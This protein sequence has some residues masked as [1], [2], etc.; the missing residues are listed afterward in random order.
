MRNDLFLMKCKHAN[1]ARDSKG[2]PVCV[3]CGC[4]DVVKK[5]KQPTDGLEGRTAKCPDCGSTTESR[6]DL[7]FFKHN[8]DR[9]FDSYYCGCYG[10]K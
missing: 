9:E 8:P 3:I 2:N 5:I 7:P 1:N 10:W 4:V 6:W